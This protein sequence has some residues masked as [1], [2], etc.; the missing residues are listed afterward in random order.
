L[1][2][3]SLALVSSSSVYAASYTVKAG[4]TLYKVSKAYNTNTNILTKDN[5]LLSNTIY[6]GQVLDVPT[7]TYNVVNNDTLFFIAKKYS[8]SLEKLRVA[9]DKLGDIIHPGDIINIPT[10]TDNGQAPPRDASKVI[11]YSNSDV[12]LLARLITAEAS[13]ESA[14]A[15]LSVGAV[16]VNRVQS[17]QYPGNISSVIN[18][19]CD[20]SYQ[21]TPV[22]NGMINKV[23]SKA[24]TSAAYQ[25]LNGTDPTNG[26]LFFFDNTVTNEWLTSK[27]V[28]TTL[29]NLIFAY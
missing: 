26:A 8:I 27:P 17:S 28:A 3:L 21:F 9:N 4:D 14:D 18:E 1:L 20:G 7:N 22:K 23:A 5:K 6:T 25:A 29:G 10:S 16:V 11:K 12:D 15:M 24:A 19:V 13:G 2:A